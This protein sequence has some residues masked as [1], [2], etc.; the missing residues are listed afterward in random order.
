M[1]FQEQNETLSR[2]KLVFYI[3]EAQAGKGEAFEL[4]RRQYSPLID[5]Q[6]RKHLPE[7]VSYDDAEDM[8]QEALIA[9]YT[10]VMNY[11]RGEEGVEFGLYAKI[12]IGNRL[13]TFLREY[14]KRMGHNVVSLDDIGMSEQ[15][16]QLD[17]VSLS[18]ISHERMQMLI[19]IIGSNLSDLE[20]S[21]WWQY[22]AGA[23][24]ADIAKRLNIENVRSVEN[25]IYR[26]RRK[27]RKLL[28]N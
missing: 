14:R 12:C 7:D 25:A 5:S 20:K 9:F 6:V 10:A 19:E 8:R 4:L 24:A 1:N 22:V 21:V 11:D 3:G 18:V 23:S 15:D 17:D 26:I 2:Q 28:K 27:L 16:T 13:K